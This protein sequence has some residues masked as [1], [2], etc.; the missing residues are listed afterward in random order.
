MTPE[1]GYF[2]QESDVN[3]ACSVFGLD[4]VNYRAFPDT[5][6]V[7][8]PVP[9]PPESDHPRAV[10]SVLTAP[11]APGPAHVSAAQPPAV[12]A[13]AVTLPEAPRPTAAPQPATPCFRAGMSFG[14]SAQQGPGAAVA[15]FP[16]L[17]QAF[18]M[19]AAAPRQMAA[20]AMAG[21][22]LRP[23]APRGPQPAAPQPAAPA[24]AKINAFGQAFGAAFST[25]FGNAPASPE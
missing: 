20:F 19:S 6:P 25:A 3:R 24:Q 1:R 17:A 18:P 9:K 16:L 4:T 22:V 13:P 14:G 7:P 8:P 21:T 5:G 11:L 10:E 23:M 12:G 15:G 2:G